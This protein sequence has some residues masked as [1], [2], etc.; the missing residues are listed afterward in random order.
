VLNTIT[1]TP[2]IRDLLLIN[3]LIKVK[4]DIQERYKYGGNNLNNAVF[5]VMYVKIGIQYKEEQ[6]K[7]PHS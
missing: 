7:F 3:Q 1:Q 4:R 2:D 5:M 6:S